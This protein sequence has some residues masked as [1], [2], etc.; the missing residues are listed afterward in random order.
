MLALAAKKT[1][2]QDWSNWLRRRAELLTDMEALVAERPML[3]E[4]LSLS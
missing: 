1:G 3:T 4:V 2:R